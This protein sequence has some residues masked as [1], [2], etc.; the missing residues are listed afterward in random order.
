MKNKQ[1]MIEVSL[2]SLVAPFFYGLA[3]D[4]QQKNTQI[5]G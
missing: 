3:W 4:I 1:I 2:K 5:T